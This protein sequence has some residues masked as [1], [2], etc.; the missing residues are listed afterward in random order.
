M[1]NKSTGPAKR[2]LIGWIAYFAGEKKS[3][4]IV[5][6]FFALLSVACCIAPYFII[7]RIVQQL[8]SGVRDWNLFLK[9]CGIT[10]AFWAGNVLFH[11]ISTSMSHI[12]TFNLLGNIRKRM[13]DKL[14]RVPL[15]TVLDM[16]S[17]SLK[18]IMIERIDSMETTLA[19]IV[20]EYTSNIIL[21]IALVAYL[22]VLDWRLAL[23]CMA[24]LPIGFVAMCFMF[25]DGTARFNYALEK[26][27]ALNDTA[28][29]YINGIEVIKAFGKS[30]SSYERFVVAAQEG[31]ACY[32]EWMRDCIW[33]HAVATVVTPS[34]LLSL[35]PIGGF[36][37]L[38][39]SIDA[40]L[41][42]TVIV[43]AVSAIQPFLIAFTY[44]DDI[45]KAGAIFGEVGSIMNLPELERPAVDVKTPADNSIVLKDVHFSYHKAGESL[46]P[47]SHSVAPTPPSAGDTPATPPCD[48]EI[49]HGISMTLPQG[50][51]TA[52]VGPSGSGKSTIAR[53]IASLW[54]V[55]SGSI[56]IGGVN[57][58]DLS[59][60]EYNR[61]VAYV[62]Q[63]NFLFD[64]SVRENI[65][66]GRPNAT[67]REVEDITRKAGCYDFIKSLEKGFDTIVGGSGAHLSGGERQRIAIA[68]AMMKDAPI[69]ILDE[70]TAYTDPENE[71]IIQKSVAQ[72]V[73]GKTL[74][75]IAHRLSTV[76]DADMLYV[77]K[78]GKID[79]CG[80]HE[81][82]LTKR[83]GLYKKMWEAHI[84]S[85][86]E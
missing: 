4:Y 69:V 1:S 42:I 9:E 3:Q 20:P 76:K 8:L 27:K 49:L 11:A 41:F 86:D 62:S 68:R 16:P 44:H 13:C 72:L 29:E 35:L 46:P 31:S 78:D 12:A 67:D 25:K 82:L 14:T 34:L 52:F 43:L 70:A 28:V 45:A 61:R 24:T 22:F 64:M 23:A 77:I 10:A 57:I 84:G 19:H 17:G 79:S 75:V 30:K 48:S 73:K 58:K 54:D 51:Y 18:S 59:L 21:S 15:G 26:T 60:E 38:R 5:S 37:F 56:E 85:R 40:S 6:V 53:L 71:A 66:L 63:D 55:D 83:G 7:A 32:V 50:S 47:A 65:R 36:M 81:K 74:I 33:P 2:G 80:T 39:G